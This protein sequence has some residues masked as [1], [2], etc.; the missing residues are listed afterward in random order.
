[1]EIHVPS[2]RSVLHSIYPTTGMRPVGGVDVCR[3]LQEVKQSIREMK[4]IC[5]KAWEADSY[6]KFRRV[7]IIEPEDPPTAADFGPVACEYRTTHAAV[8]SR[9]NSSRIF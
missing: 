5:N 9:A 8:A 7:L 4:D 2:P 1:M 6:S 3:Y